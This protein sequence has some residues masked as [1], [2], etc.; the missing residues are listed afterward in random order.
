A[1]A[2]PTSFLQIL[3]GY[4]G[5]YAGVKLSLDDAGNLVD[6]TGKIVHKKGEFTEKG[7]FYY[8]SAGNKLGRIWSKIV[9]AVTDAATKTVDAMKGV[10]TNLITK[11]E[12]AEASY[13]LSN[14]EW[15]KENNRIS[16]FSKAEVEGLAAAMKATDKGKVVVNV[17]T[18]DGADDKENTKLSKARAEVVHNMLVTLGVPDGRISFKGMGTGANKVDIAAK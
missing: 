6:G 10:F 5:Q 8:D 11:K 4:L 15:Q 1:A 3:K 2:I 14:I 16:N 12:G 18:N 17:Y 13:S 7:G 9:K